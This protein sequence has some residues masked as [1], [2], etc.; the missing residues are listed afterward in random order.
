MDK[1][2][3][4]AGGLGVIFFLGVWILWPFGMYGAYYEFSLPFFRGW[5]VIAI[6]WIFAALLIVTFLP[7]IEGRKSIYYTIL[8]QKQH[9]TKKQAHQ[10]SGAAPVDRY[11]LEGKQTLPDS[12]KGESGDQTPV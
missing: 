1:M 9:L 8:G 10:V 4:I 12:P 11:D 7:P 3:K 5:I 6:I 2:S